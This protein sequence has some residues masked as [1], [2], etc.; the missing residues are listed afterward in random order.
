MHIGSRGIIFRVE[1]LVSEGEY[2]H[3][4]P[5][6]IND[7]CAIKQLPRDVNMKITEIETF[8]VDAGWWPWVYVK[9]ETDDGLI[10]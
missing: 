1:L 7:L 6:S 3:F 10:G 9:V 8:V 4:S 2:L 5:I